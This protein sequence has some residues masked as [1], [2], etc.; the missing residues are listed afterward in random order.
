MFS[1]FFYHLFLSFADFSFCLPPPPWLAT[2]CKVWNWLSA[3]LPQYSPLWSIYHR[4]YWTIRLCGCLKN[5]WLR[6][7]L[8]NSDPISSYWLVNSGYDPDTWNV[9]SQNLSSFFPAQQTFPT[10]PTKPS[11]LTPG[12]QQPLNTLPPLAPPLQSIEDIYA[13]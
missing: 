13:A 2:V 8:S 3:F 9:T 4:R 6:L 7:D 5:Q 12:L 10:Q 1:V 11:L